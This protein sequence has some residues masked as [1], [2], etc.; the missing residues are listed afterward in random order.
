MQADTILHWHRNLHRRH[1]ARM[2]RPKRPGRP[3]TIQSIRMLVLR[4]ANE[5]PNWGY[6]RIHGELLVLG[7]KLA[8]STVWQILTG[9]RIYVLGVIEHASRRIRILGATPHPTTAWVTQTTRNLIMD[10]DHAGYRARFLIH[11][12]D[13]TF[14]PLFD[15]ILTDTGIQVI[16]S[17]IQTPR[18]NSIM[19]RRIQSCRH[20]PLDRTS[21]WNQRHLLHTLSEYEKFYNNHRPHQDIANTRPLQPLPQP[22][23]SQDQITHLNIR[24]RPR[25]GGL[26]NEYHHAA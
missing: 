2:S 9:A 1:H 22:I 21:I 17:G 18:T 15:I 5:N 16:L 12:R 13:G 14:P 26:L 19:E 6:R 8:A 11:D 24:Q 7:I 23:T 25:L 20:E 4:L 10:L 3:R